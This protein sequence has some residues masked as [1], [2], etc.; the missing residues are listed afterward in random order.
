[1]NAII[2]TLEETAELDSFKA[3]VNNFTQL[4]TDKTRVS[5]LVSYIA[6]KTTVSKDK[7]KVYVNEFLDR[8]DT[9]DLNDLSKKVIRTS[10]IP[11]DEDEETIED[12]LEEADTVDVTY[13]NEI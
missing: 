8:I 6:C 10:V 13:L 3:S 4:A 9:E 5:A 2:L 12:I 7:V 11:E 1:M